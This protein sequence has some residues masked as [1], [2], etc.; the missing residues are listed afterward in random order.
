[1]PLNPSLAYAVSRGMRLKYMDRSTYRTK[2]A[3]DVIAALRKEFGSF[4]LLPEGGSNEVAVRGCSEIPAEIEMDF[5]AICC[6][7]G[8]GG[9]LAGIAAGLKPEQHAIGFSALKGG[10]FLAHEVA[11]LQQRALGGCSGN[12]RIEQAFHFGGFAKKTA[13]LD[14]FI[15]DFFNRNG[16]ALERVY[17]AKM[18]YGLYALIRAGAFDPGSRVI[19]VITG[20]KCA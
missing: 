18:M 6:P 12:W 20:A 2:S 19:A 1:M 5:D 14:R 10:A 8:T 11:E 7:C 15:A 4:Y 17:V 3:P 16:L 13:E 9:T